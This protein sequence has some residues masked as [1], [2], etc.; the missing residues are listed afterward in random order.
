LVSEAQ[1]FF[2]VGAEEIVLCFGNLPPLFPLKGKVVTF[3]QNRYLVENIT[4]RGLKLKTKLRLSIERIWFYITSSRVDRFLVQTVSMKNLLLKKTFKRIP[5][6]IF[7]YTDEL[8][9]KE[10]FIKS[11]NKYDF[12]YIASGEAHKNHKALVRAWIILAQENLFPSLHLTLDESLWIELI[13]LINLEKKRFNLKIINLGKLDR[14]ELGAVYGK[15]KA[16]IY[17]SKFESFGLPLIEASQLGV[18][19]LASELD[20]VRDLI[21]PDETFNPDSPMSIAR[22][23]KRFMK[24]PDNKQQ[25]FQAKDLINFLISELDN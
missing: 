14:K 22:A 21:N 18:S 9:L 1:L 4:L 13:N 16:L 2:E 3:V 11:N 20:Y 10:T 24:F 15:T 17:P 23:V 8:L 7:P 19:I 5:V 25:L 6:D 12:C